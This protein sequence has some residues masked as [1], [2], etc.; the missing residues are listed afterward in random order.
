[1]PVAVAERQCDA[2]FESF[3]ENQLFIFIMKVAYILPHLGVAGGIERITTDLSNFFVSQ[4]VEVK[5]VSLSS[6]E[7]MPFE[8]DKRVDVMHLGL[9]IR[10]RLDLNHCV[11]QAILVCSDADIIIGSHVYINSLLILNKHLVKGK[12]VVTQHDNCDALSRLRLATNVVLYRFADSF[13]TLSQ[14][15]S[16]FY[17]RFLVKNIVIP[18]GTRIS[19]RYSWNPESRTLIAIGRLC[20]IKGFD[21][22]I[23]AFSIVHNQY[24]DW[25]LNIFGG[26]FD[27]D[28]RGKLEAMILSKGLENIVELK[29]VSSNIEHELESSA[30]YVLSSRSES[31]SLTIIEALSKGLPVVSTDIPA[32]QSIY[33][34]AGII[35]CRRTDVQSMATAIIKLI[36]SQ[37]LMKV[38]SKE[39]FDQS[40]RFQLEMVGQQW[41]QLFNHLCRK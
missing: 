21:T 9:K 26:T 20:E 7:G 39:A 41:L 35:Y 37:Q 5:I 2:T 30:G 3:D 8:I 6:K 24:P 22:L 36:S 40:L 34:K 18:N 4:G 31:F 23:A 38:K 28:Y 25:K 15:D 13:V 10:S 1:M 11:R 33:G 14:V 32:V 12:V 29:G 17:K 16:S 19:R 27:R